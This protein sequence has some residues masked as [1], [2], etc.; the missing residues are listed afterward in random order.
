MKVTISHNPKEHVLSF[1]L[2]QLFALLV[3]FIISA[4]L[5]GQ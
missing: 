2:K 5:T 4:D 1:G 3:P